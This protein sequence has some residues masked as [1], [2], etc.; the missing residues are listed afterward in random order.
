MYASIVGAI[1]FVRWLMQI[2]DYVVEIKG[3]K[4]DLG[5][6]TFLRLLQ[7]FSARLVL[8]VFGGGGAIWGFRYV[9]FCIN[10]HT[11]F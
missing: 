2:K 6:G 1:F 7:I 8:E 4:V 10:I 5:E 11:S 3:G 9:Q